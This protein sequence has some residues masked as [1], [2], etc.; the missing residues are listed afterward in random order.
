[1][2]ERDLNRVKTDLSQTG[3]SLTSACFGFLTA[4]KTAETQGQAVAERER[5]DRAN[6][7]S[8]IREKTRE[9][10]E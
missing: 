5:S 10:T 1:T 8:Q 3:R 4:V 9:I 6:C 7:D 2:T